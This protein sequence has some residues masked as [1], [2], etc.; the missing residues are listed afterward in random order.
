MFQGA[1]IKETLTDELILDYLADTRGRRHKGT[2]GIVLISKM[3]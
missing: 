1:I 3:Q 2:G